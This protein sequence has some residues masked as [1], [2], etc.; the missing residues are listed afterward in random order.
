MPSKQIVHAHDAFVRTVMSD[1]RI[2][3]EFFK[4]H[5]P[6]ALQ[7]LIDF[8]HLILQPRSYIDAVRKE[9]TV[10][11]LYK[12]HL[13]GEEAYLYLIVEHQ[14]SPDELMPFRLL[15]YTCNIMDHHLKTTQQ[16]KLPLVYPMV[17][18]HAE[19]PYPYTT[20]IKDLV[21][22]PLELIEQ[23]FLKPFQLIDLGQINDEELKQHAW[24]G[25]MEFVL[26]HIFA[27]D[28]LPHLQEIAELMRRIT[29]SGGRDYV[30]IVLQYALERGEL[31]NKQAFFELVNNEISL[32]VGEKVMTL[33]EQLRDEG[34]MEGRMEGRAEGRIEERIE[35]AKRLLTAGTEVTFVAKI[36]GI[37]VEKL[38]ALQS[39][40]IAS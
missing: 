18:Y 22:A 21:D 4:I 29:Q 38:K 1:P 16:K 36:T 19:R 33:A 3:R 2:A 10:D 39:K 30:S 31:K 25:V 40:E 5:L 32:E 17:I 7:A 23:Y 37:S 24:V 26:K 11:I 35:V 12:T 9:A 13:A 15:K 27:R 28:V 8:D 6:A 34:R 20:N 14:S